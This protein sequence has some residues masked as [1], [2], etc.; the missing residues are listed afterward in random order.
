MPTWASEVPSRRGLAG[1]GLAN[2]QTGK[3]LH[4]EGIIA[5]KNS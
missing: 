5:F 2:F 4:D 1:V 3:S